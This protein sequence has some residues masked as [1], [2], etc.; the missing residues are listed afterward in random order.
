MILDRQDYPP[1]CQSEV[2]P[3]V[4]IL[5]PLAAKPD[6]LAIAPQAD[7]VR[8]GNVHLARGGQHAA[9]GRRVNDG[10]QVPG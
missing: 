1:W 3:G 9:T 2:V 4:G 6:M 10:H 8:V 5:L 7:K